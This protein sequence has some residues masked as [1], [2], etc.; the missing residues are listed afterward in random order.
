MV[1]VNND[2]P[3]LIPEGKYEVSDFSK[4]V[5]PPSNKSVVLWRYMDLAKLVM[6]LS[7][8]QLHFARADVFPDRHEGSFTKPMW[9]KLEVQF[10]KRPGLRQIV[11]KMFKQHMKENAFVSCWCMGPESEAMWKLYCGDN[12]GVAITAAYQD[13]EASFINQDLLMTKVKYLDYQVD[14]FPL[15]KLFYPLFH[16][17]RAFAYEQEV[18]IVE[19]CSD[20]MPVG[21]IVT[22]HPPTEEEKRAHEDELKLGEELKVERGKGILLEFDVET[23]ARNIVVH[24][25]AHEW[26][27]DAVK[28]V[29]EKFTPVLR[30]KVEWS[31]LRTEPLY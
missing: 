2:K 29:V 28:L 9:E 18:R 4:V 23:L 31:S 22:G 5:P 6:L 12:Y 17:R 14:E 20:Q 11:S 27:F 8:K 19:W 26:Y 3:F 25:Y 1:N 7:N 10:A 16:K 21:M 24:P 13:I 15:D 30:E